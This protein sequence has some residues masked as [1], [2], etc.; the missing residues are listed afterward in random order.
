MVAVPAALAPVVYGLLNI[1]SATGI[2]F[3]NKAGE[4]G[5]AATTAQRAPR[6]L[7]G[8]P[9]VRATRG[10]CM[11]RWSRALRT[12]GTAAAA[13]ASAPLCAPPA[14]CSLQR[15][16]L[17]LHLCPHA[18]THAHHLGGHARLPA[19]EVGWGAAAAAWALGLGWVLTAA[20]ADLYVQLC[21]QWARS[22]L[23][24]PPTSA[25]P[26]SRPAAQDV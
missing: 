2:V 14:T 3:A 4:R 13:A 26:P 17:P 8:L 10:E 5:R 20:A 25:P 7:P 15:L 11:A 18:H 1:A 16:W 9:D 24:Q 19:G 12:L 22:V 23:K 21:A 6:G